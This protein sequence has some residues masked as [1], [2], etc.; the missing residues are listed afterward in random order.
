MDTPAMRQEEQAASAVSPD[1]AGG[2]TIGLQLAGD[3]VSR[4]TVASCRP[5]AAARVFVGKVG[6]RIPELA[7]R[8]FA[9]CG[10][11]QGVAAVTALEA[12]RGDAPVPETVA[13][14]AAVLQ[15][16]L[17]REHLTRILAGWT[18]A[19]GAPVASE[20]AIWARALPGRLEATAFPH[21]GLLAPGGEDAG[22][23]EW[24][25]LADELEGVLEMVLGVSPA[26]FLT[27]EGVGALDAYVAERA[28]AAQAPAFLAHL[29][30]R[31]LADLGDA[32]LQPLP[33]LDPEQLDA[34]LA[35]G[36]GDAFAARPE[37]DGCVPETGPLARMGDQAPVTAARAG[38]GNG[39]LARAVARLTELAVVPDTLRELADPGTSPAIQGTSVTSGTGLGQV[40]AARGQLV[41]RL[42]LSGGTVTE[43]RILAPT[44][45]NFHPRGCLVRALEGARF[46]DGQ[47]ART[48][49]GYLIGGID[50]CV[51]YSL[52]LAHA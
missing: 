7:R 39:V 19:L 12:A 49:A 4:V 17:A 40:A 30:D 29:R 31:G 35:G 13:A 42:A 23:G 10:H 1:P 33:A 16:E 48:G 21:G 47:A 6:G 28:G 34:S 24:Q 37:W 26:A 46:P 9:V 14:R 44:E 41:H 52:E 8:L 2:L 45:W 15:A 22:I 50:P 20:R 36:G 3:R 43:Y 11:A 5:T 27:L 32:P 25:G 38:Y 51:D 18:A